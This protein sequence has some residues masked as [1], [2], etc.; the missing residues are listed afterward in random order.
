MERY[1]PVDILQP[2][3]KTFMIIESED[4]MV[5]NILPEAAII[6]AFRYKG[7]VIADHM[8]LP[9]MVL[10]GLRKSPRVLSYVADT[11]NLLVVFRDNGATAFFR[12][13]LHELFGNSI[14]LDELLPGHDATYVL[15]Q[16]AAASSDVLRISI[17]ERFLLS[18][19]RPLQPDMLIQQAVKSIR[20]AN[21]NIR[22]K[23]LLKNL[24][25]SQDPFEKRFR[26]VTGAT[27]KQFASI[28]RLRNIINQ[29]PSAVTSLTDMAHT[30]GYF[31]QSHFIKDFK[32]FTGKTPRDFYASSSWW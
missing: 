1:Q 26:K 22:I 15:E 18:Q 7:A 30:A 21:G 24:H 28:I 29:N 11:A 2:F 5:N 31:D 23:E 14:A 9:D 32:I 16:L 25:I 12:E 8:A 20:Q 17:I 4:G 19:L 6:M 13:P 10:T 27:A 3:I